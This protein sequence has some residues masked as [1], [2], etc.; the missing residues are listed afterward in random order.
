MIHR[1]Y[2]ILFGLA[3]LIGGI[4]LFTT[5]KPEPPL[6]PTLPAIEPSLTFSNTQ[7]WDTDVEKALLR[8]DALVDTSTI[9]LPP[10]PPNTSATTQEEI[11]LLKKWSEERGAKHEEILHELTVT[12]A[13]F[14]SSTFGT[15]I[16]KDTRLETYYFFEEINASFLTTIVHFKHTF[17]RVR[18][19]YLDPD[20]TTDI[21][22]PGHPAYPSGHASQSYLFALILGDLD[23]HNREQ[24]LASAYRIAHNREIAGV[25]YPSDSAAGRELAQQYYDKL[26][27]TPWY[28]VHFARAQQ[29]WQ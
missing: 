12:N 24:Y 21:P 9:T 29:E 22:V 3:I 4:V 16:N 1:T 11:I 7:A 25:H 13:H 6:P 10:P 18:P 15:L 20:L 19:S 23:P 27:E 17:D 28:H 8:T 26:K 14:G 2:S 5:M